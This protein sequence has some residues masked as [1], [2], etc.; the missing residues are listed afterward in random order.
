[1]R[2]RGV[3]GGRDHRCRVSRMTGSHGTHTHRAARVHSDRRHAHRRERRHR[4]I[5]TV[6]IDTL[7]RLNA[8]PVAHRAADHVAGVILAV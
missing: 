4:Q 1:M 5:R 3:H 6:R 2:V 7:Q 8:F